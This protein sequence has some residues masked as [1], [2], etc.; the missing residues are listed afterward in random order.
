[1]EP[2]PHAVGH[3]P[4]TAAAHLAA[5][6]RSKTLLEAVPV[7]AVPVPPPS[8]ASVWAGRAPV[9]SVLASAPLQQHCPLCGSDPVV[10]N[11]WVQCDGC[12]RYYH[13]VCAQ[14]IPAATGF[15]SAFF[16]P[17]PDCRQMGAMQGV[18]PGPAASVWDMLDTPLGNFLTNKARAAS[19]SGQLLAVKVLSDI[20]R[21]P[22]PPLSNSFPF[23]SKAVFAFQRL[24]CGAEV[25]RTLIAFIPRL[26]VSSPRQNT[27]G[28][29]KL[30]YVKVA[31]LPKDEI[32]CLLEALP[33]ASL[34]PAPMRGGS[35]RRAAG[36]AGD[37]VRHVRARVRLRVPAAQ[38]RPRVRP[39]HRQHPAL[40]PGAGPPR[41][42]LQ[43]EHLTLRHKVCASRRAYSS[44]LRD[45]AC[46][47]SSGFPA[48]GGSTWRRQR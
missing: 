41:P 33:A 44:R 21:S 18:G 48:R 31:W 27:N 4:H 13:T 24:A 22:A 29:S 20:F 37:A 6:K 35:R 19:R 30:L 36:P 16:C 25:L 40:R 26:P 1:M 47:S 17:R 23:R 10:D 45:R 38:R 14:Y 5:R 42:A 2:R 12:G 34:L 15:K 28:A 11:R 9:A 7:P 46:P 32:S 8:G 39:V 43:A 3:A